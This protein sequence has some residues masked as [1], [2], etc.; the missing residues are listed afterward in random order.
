VKQLP[1]AVFFDRDG[2]LM[3]DAHYIKSPDQVR[4]LP[5]AARAVKRINDARIP[6]IV[7]TNQSGIDRGIFTVADYEA[8]KD[9]FEALLRAEGAH[10]DASYYCPHHPDHTGACKCRKPEPKMF[11]DAMRDFGLTP[12]NVAY[13]GDRWRDV[14]ASKTLGGRGVLISSA[15]TEDEDRERA[16]ADGIVSVPSITAAVDLIL[17]LTDADISP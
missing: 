2:T 15:M 8:V 10:I 12:R 6:A 14:A 3:E 5:G 9:R 4:L 16:R 7:V 11:E 13:V 17:D 1:D